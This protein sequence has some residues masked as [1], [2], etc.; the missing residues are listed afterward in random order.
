MT[1]LDNVDRYVTTGGDSV[2]VKGRTDYSLAS[3][4]KQHSD[5]LVISLSCN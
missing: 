4:D 5:F 3:Y 1:L 2:V